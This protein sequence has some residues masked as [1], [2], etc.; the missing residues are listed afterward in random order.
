MAHE[1]PTFPRPTKLV[2]DNLSAEIENAGYQEVEVQD[3]GAEI[4]VVA[5]TSGGN[6]IGEPSRNAIQA[7]IDAHTGEP[8]EEQLRPLLVQQKIDEAVTAMRNELANWPADLPN[9]ANSA[10]IVGRINQVSAQLRRNT[11]RIGKLAQL[12]RGLYD[13]PE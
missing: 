9:N 13:I 3:L 1:W 6:P 7:I 12:A 2:G 5:L 4:R 11:E 10:S 8:T